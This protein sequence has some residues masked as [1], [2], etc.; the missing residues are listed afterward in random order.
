[1]DDQAK[2][3]LEKLETLREQALYGPEDQREEAEQAYEKLRATLFNHQSCELPGDEQTTKELPEV[4]AYTCEICGQTFAHK[5]G[6]PLIYAGQGRVT[7]TVCEA[8]DRQ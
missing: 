1:M 7:P 6:E 4:A 2:A 3:E 5:E 8:C